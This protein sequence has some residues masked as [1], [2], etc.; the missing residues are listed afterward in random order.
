MRQ[1]RKERKREQIK[2]KKRTMT[3]KECKTE[4]WRERTR[5]ERERLTGGMPNVRVCRYV[6]E[7][8]RDCERN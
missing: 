8:K 7:I 2:E 3:I 6:K 5:K 4:K 1:L